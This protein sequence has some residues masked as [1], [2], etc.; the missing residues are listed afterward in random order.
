MVFRDAESAKSYLIKSGFPVGKEPKSAPM[1]VIFFIVTIGILSSLIYFYTKK[2]GV[3]KSNLPYIAGVGLSIAITFYYISIYFP[4]PRAGTAVGA[5]TVP[6]VWAFL[7]TIVSTMILYQMKLSFKA[8]VSGKVRLVLTLTALLFGYVIII[9][10]VGF[11]LATALMLIAGML[12]LK[13]KEIKT[14]LL[15]TTF[16]ILFMYGIFYKVLQVPLPTGMF[17]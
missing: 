6:Q 11:L 14:I 12:I 8:P 7:L 16:V 3:E 15:T 4:D 13:H 5:A 10:F 2:N 9:S 17:F 1:P